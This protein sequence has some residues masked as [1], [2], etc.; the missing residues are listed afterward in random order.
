MGL[1][2]EDILCLA[3]HDWDYLWQR[4]Q[5]LMWRLAQDGNRV[6]YVDALGVRT[7]GIR[8]WRRVLGRL[9]KWGIQ[10]V[11]GVRQS[12]T[13][14]YVYSPV[15]LPFLDSPWVVRVNSWWLGFSIQRIL[16][17]LGFGD[18]IVWVY[19]PTP[20]VMNL[21]NRLRRKLLVYDCADA[22]IHNP[23]GTVAGLIASE[24]WVLAQADLVFTSS[25]SLHK[26]AV[27]YNSN[28]HLVPA[29]VNLDR[30]PEVLE[31]NDRSPADLAVIPTPR[32]CYFG[33]IDDRL[34]QGLLARVAQ[35]VPGGSLVLL[36]TIRTDISA[37]LQM[38]NVH[39]LGPKPH[40]ELASYLAGMDV[41]IMPYQLNDYTRAI[42]PAK[43]H[44]CLAIG[45]PLV[46]TDLPEVRPFRHV[47]R[48]AREADEFL[49]QVFEAL[50][51]EDQCV[52]AQRRCV[53][54]ANSWQ[55]RYE[56]IAEKLVK[57]LKA[58]GQ[59]KLTTPMESGVF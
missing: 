1:T 19:L 44:E 33:Q 54:E 41:F 23:R 38:S 42:Y 7:P 10:L 28:V 34:D 14:V 32:I 49:Q 59:A 31:R 55:S 5:E 50:A 37:L 18:L 13:N 53:A 43:L 52:R 56:I 47:V 9:R 39:W 6:L 40:T 21:V 11:R 22:Q 24:R 8:D 48:I 15:I 29:G 16:Q 25:A 30:F 35:S 20:T 17:H 27:T 3:S 4:H 57:C 26:R 12:A 45:K 51:E 36:G 46:T 58:K 2:G